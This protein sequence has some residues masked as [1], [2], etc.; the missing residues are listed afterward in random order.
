MKLYIFSFLFIGFSCGC[1]F[2]NGD[3]PFRIND[4]ISSYHCWPYDVNV[5]SVSEIKPDT[6]FFTYPLGNFSESNARFE[7]SSWKKYNE[8]DSSNWNGM[9]ETLKQCNDNVDLYNHIIK[10][11]KVYYCGSYRNFK[12]QTGLKRY[13]NE[14][15]FLDFTNKELHVF[16]DINKIY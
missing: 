5:Y 13:Y 11:N 15:L 10:G 2:D 6:L 9:L 14:I 3:F 7:I 4:E 1:H 16:K 8:I 12:V